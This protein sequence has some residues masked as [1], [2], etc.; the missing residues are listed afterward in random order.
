MRCSR[1]SDKSQALIMEGNSGTAYTHKGRTHHTQSSSYPPKR[2]THSSSHYFSLC[3]LSALFF[4]FVRFSN[5][6]VFQACIFGHQAFS[7]SCHLSHRCLTGPA[8]TQA[9]SLLFSGGLNSPVSGSPARSLMDTRPR[10]QRAFNIQQMAGA[11]RNLPAVTLARH[12]TKAQ[13]Y[14]GLRFNPPPVTPIN[15][16]HYLLL[17]NYDCSLKGAEK[18]HQ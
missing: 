16:I 3:F 4:L 14:Q 10:R 15:Q 6:A 7:P 13:Q 18:P 11:R 8:L 9:F 1:R 12:N 5:L 17:F 2:N